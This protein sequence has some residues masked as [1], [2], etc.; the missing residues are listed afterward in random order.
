MIVINNP[1]NFYYIIFYLKFNIK[2]DLLKIRS[3]LYSNKY[4]LLYRIIEEKLN[5][6]SE[7]RNS[8]KTDY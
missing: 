4:S 8:T 6:L 5:Y 3:N 2:I 1:T 7:L